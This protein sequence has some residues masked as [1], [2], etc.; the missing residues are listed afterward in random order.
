MTFILKIVLI[1]AISAIAQLFLPF[2]SVALVAF[3]V[4][5][6]TS[7]NGFS[8]FSAGFLAVIILWGLV[9]AII[10]INTSSILSSKIAQVL[11][12]RGN[13]TLLMLLT[14]LVGGLVGGFGALSGSMFRVLFVKQKKA[15]YYS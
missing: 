13:V 7:G 10:D 4:C 9:A 12:L 14:V 5:L 3:I 8:A 2:W 11:P 6:V 15:G 1:A